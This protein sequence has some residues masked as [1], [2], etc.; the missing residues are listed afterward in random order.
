M[1]VS[2]DDTLAIHTAGSQ[3]QSWSSPSAV[4]PYASRWGANRKTSKR[5]NWTKFAEMRD[6]LAYGKT[7]G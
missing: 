6:E 3:Q 7:K 5:I 1:S 4:P 2:R